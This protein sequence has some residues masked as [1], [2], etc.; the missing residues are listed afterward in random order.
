MAHTM[1]QTTPPQKIPSGFLTDGLVTGNGD[2]ALTWGGTPGVIR[3]YIS[4]SD[5]WKGVEPTKNGGGLCPLGTIEIQIPHLQLSPF[6]VEQ[7]MD[8]ARLVGRFAQNH[9]DAT[10][11][12]IVCATENTILLEL[13]RAHPGLSVSTELVPIEANDAVC[14]RGKQGNLQYAVRS[15]E[16]PSFYFS[17]AG[18]AVMTEV[19]RKRVAGREVIR[20]AI[21]VAT[22]HDT[23]AYRAQSLAAAEV[24]DDEAFEQKLAAHET[25]W[26]KFWSASSLTLEDKELENHWYSSLYAI[27]CCARNKKFPPG[28]WGN[29]CTADGMAWNGDYHLNYNYQAPFYALAATN[30]PELLE[31]YDAPLLDF[32]PRAKRYAREYLGC[33][34]VLYP[35]SIGPLG[36][37]VDMRPNVREHGHLFL[38]Q[39]SNA[40]Y[41]AVVQ[42]FRWYTFGEADYARTCALPFLKEVAAF[43]AD[44]LAEVDGV[45]HIRN[46]AL[47]EVP[48]YKGAAYEPEADDGHPDNDPAVSLGLVRM[49]LRGLLDICN[50]LEIADPAM[51]QWEHILAHLAPIET[52]ECEGVQILRPVED[53]TDLRRLPNELTYPVGEITRADAK[54]YEAAQNH[55]RLLDL[56]EG[57]NT[58]CS[59]YPAAARFGV[60][61]DEILS[62]IKGIIATRGLPSGMFWFGGGGVENSAGVPATMNEML[63]QSYDGVLRLFACWN[64]ATPVSFHGFRTYGGFAVDATLADGV[65]TATIA[66]KQG[67]T[68]TLTVPTDGYV[69][70][71]ADGVIALSAD[72]PV[73]VETSV[74]EVLTVRRAQA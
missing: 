18:I 65:F 56:W 32:M 16:D 66:S 30:H 6:H 33:R 74:G 11:T 36:M 22:S 69:L 35:V 17:T 13:D 68:L 50:R 9:L 14:E 73:C 41:A 3:L 27:A 15:F 12:A 26:Q 44:Y 45:Y 5:F 10:L 72:T 29:F 46:D 61:P 40:A 63:V 37:E 4:K 49:V 7:Q 23:A 54:L 39:K 70:C 31:C 28:L 19:S 38:G 51:A 59:Y 58:F 67:R 53:A 42:L 25:W 20:W 8:E 60:D 64:L 48:F 62:H 71:K 2:L 1:I 21:V 57:G 34:G 24:L 43:W 47:N 55:H 52:V